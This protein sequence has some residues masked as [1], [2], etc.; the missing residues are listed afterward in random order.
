MGEKR[1]RSDEEKQARYQSILESAGDLFIREEY[2][3]ITIA[4][5][6]V[7]AGI[8]KGTIYLYFPTKEA[9][10]LDLLWQQLEESWQHTGEILAAIPEDQL[11]PHFLM[12]QLIKEILDRPLQRRLM[13]LLHSVL[14]QKI[15][16]ERAARFKLNMLNLVKEL[17]TLLYTRFGI[18]PDRGR[19]L[20][21][22]FYSL[23]IGLG[24]MAEPARSA[25]EARTLH[26]EISALSIDLKTELTS[27]GR[28]IL[29]D[30]LRPDAQA[31]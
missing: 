27:M 25:L 26:P 10:F 6:A 2:D 30:A 9:L 19:L 11:T 29:E 22:R 3:R 15:E 5:V 14:E 16:V 21:L 31:H 17:V 24:G 20:V 4:D 13:L 7:A 18:T 8:A 12:E 1:A 28:L 23:V